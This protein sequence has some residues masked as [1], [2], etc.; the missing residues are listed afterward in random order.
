MFRDRVIKERWLKAATMNAIDKEI[1]AEIEKAVADGL[2]A[3]RPDP[4]TDL[5]SDVYSS[6]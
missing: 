5:L 2:A 3:P 1:V 6:Y 4:S